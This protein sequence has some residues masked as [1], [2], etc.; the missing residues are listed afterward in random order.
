MPDFV[1]THS[2]TK[3]WHP[4][5]SVILNGNNIGA[6]GVIHAPVWIGKEVTIGDRVKIQAFTFIPDGVTIGNDVFIG[7][8]VTFTNDRHPPSDRSHWGLVVVEDNVT[9]GANVTLLPGIRLGQGCFIAACVTVEQSVIA[10][11][12]KHRRPDFM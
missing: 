6:N 4:E 1:I 5:K 2:G 8:G 12:V 10:D 3:I 11:T 7:P 9:I